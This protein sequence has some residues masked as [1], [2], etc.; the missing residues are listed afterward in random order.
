MSDLKI[1]SGFAIPEDYHLSERKYPF[2]EME[3]G[4][5]FFIVPEYEDE[6]VQRLGNR[7]AQARQS[8]QKRVLKQSD[9]ET[10]VRF[11]Q[12]MRSEKVGEVNMNGYR[13]WR[14]Q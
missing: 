10:E 4:D 8:Y 7:I 1:Q 12:R 9:G 6:T 11:T 5:S 14:T 13:V 2:H 3:V